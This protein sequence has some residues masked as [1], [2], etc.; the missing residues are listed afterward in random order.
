MYNIY[1][2]IYI[3]I[4]YIYIIYIYIYIYAYYYRLNEEAWYATWSFMLFK[5]SSNIHFIYF[6][7]K[8]KEKLNEIPTNTPVKTFYQTI[9]KTA[10]LYCPS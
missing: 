8:Q 4:I 5:Q 7:K 10:N 1:I 2:Y 3:Y 9:A 6:S